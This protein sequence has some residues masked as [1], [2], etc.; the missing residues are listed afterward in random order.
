MHLAIDHAVGSRMPAWILLWQYITCGKAIRVF[1]ERQIKMLTNHPLSSPHLQWETVVL[2]SNVSSDLSHWLPVACCFISSDLR[3]VHVAAPLYLTS[4]MACFLV[5]GFVWS[6]ILYLLEVLGHGFTI[7][8][9]YLLDRWFD[10]T[11][12]IIIRLLWWSFS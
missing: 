11:G 1:S 4:D 6:C 10:D 9:W 5:C 3:H 8:V 12:M 2:P 7:H